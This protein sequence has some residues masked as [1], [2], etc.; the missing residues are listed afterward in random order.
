MSETLDFKKLTEQSEDLFELIVA[1]AKRAR[2][3]NALQIAQ[4]P[5]PTLEEDQEEVF[6]ETPDDQEIEN[7][8]KMEKPITIALAEMMAGK[9]EY[10]HTNIESEPEEEEIDS[11]I[12]E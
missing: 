12:E 7:F 10:R 8:D 6:D 2:Q 11:D 3:I 1:C 9:L 4:N 5:L